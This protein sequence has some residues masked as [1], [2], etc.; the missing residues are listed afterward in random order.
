MFDKNKSRER[1]QK[2]LARQEEA[3]KITLNEIDFIM[4]KNPSATALIDAL[5]VKRDRQAH[6]I[7]GTKQLIELYSD[8]P[9]QTEIPGTEKKKAPNGR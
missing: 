1:A 6:A 4:K 2:N 8:D 3:L 5:R 7:A 9:S